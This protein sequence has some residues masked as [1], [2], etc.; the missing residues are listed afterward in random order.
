MPVVKNQLFPNTPNRQK[1]R[2]KISKSK[3][4]QKSYYDRHAKP[5]EPLDIGDSTRMQTQMGTWKSG[6]IINKT[7]DRFF[8]S[9]TAD[10]SEILS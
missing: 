6:V 8:T 10:G 1:V 4:K 3:Q 7:N 2:N 5:L 9:K